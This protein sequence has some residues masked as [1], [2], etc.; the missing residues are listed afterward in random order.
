MIE[1]LHEIQ[2]SPSQMAISSL[3]LVEASRRV[4]L[5]GETHSWVREFIDCIYIWSSI[6]IVSLIKSFDLI[7]TINKLAYSVGNSSK[8]NNKYVC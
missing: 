4:N 8:V 2:I 5:D 7:F 3:V 6:V 1:E